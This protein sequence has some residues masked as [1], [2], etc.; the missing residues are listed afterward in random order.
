MTRL[1][2]ALFILLCCADAGAADLSSEARPVD[3]HT[4]KVVLDG[5]ID[6]KLK[7]GATASLVLYGE[8]ELVSRVVIT[9]TGDTL[10]IDSKMHN[11]VYHDQAHLRAELTLPALRELVSAGIG[12]TDMRGFNGADLKLG[13]E[14]AGAV[15]VN[16]NYRKLVV[17]LGG[18]GGMTVNNGDS[19]SV[20]L[21]L[22]GAGEIV[23]KGQSKSMHAHL[24][25][26]GN[27]DAQG[28]RADK[29]DM[30]M[31]GL[32]SADVYART[33]AN[34]HLSGMGSATVHG[35]PAQRS[36][37]KSGLGSISWE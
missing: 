14:G 3:G 11:H 6:L 33:A 5:V 4:M 15:T 37:T 24:G 20:D 16:G 32:G 34:L 18:V 26:I 12:S 1:I 17:H 9:Q 29:V 27:L 2:A 30:E 10:R 21:D 28:L 25:G 8:P 23:I 31:T 19:D 36:F 7:Q 35:N 13:L 22:R